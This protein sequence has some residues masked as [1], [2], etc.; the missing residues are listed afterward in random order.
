M[1]QRWLH[2][3]LNGTKTEHRTLPGAGPFSM[4]VGTRIPVRESFR[5]TPEG[6]EYLADRSDGWGYLDSSWRS[7]D[8]MP[9]RHIRLHLKITHIWDEPLQTIARRRAA[10]LAGGGA[11]IRL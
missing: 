4:V 9:S 2:S 8:E 11:H 3:L 10:L 1:S 6:I 7:P 5:E